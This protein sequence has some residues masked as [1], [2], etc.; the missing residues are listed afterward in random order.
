[1]LEMRGALLGG[2]FASE[3]AA[4]GGPAGAVGN[5]RILGLRLLAA[6]PS[7]NAFKVP[8]SQH[9]VNGRSRKAVLE[10]VGLLP[11]VAFWGVSMAAPAKT[12]TCRCPLSPT[13]VD[14]GSHRS[15]MALGLPAAQVW[16]RVPI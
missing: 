5:L 12:L 6:W 3:F 8:F 9:A 14:G 13:E 1:M 7:H 11:P 2:E 15:S 16:R 4:F 10:V